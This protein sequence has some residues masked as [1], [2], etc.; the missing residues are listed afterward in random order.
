MADGVLNLNS[1][2]ELEPLV[3]TGGQATPIPLLPDSWANKDRE[4]VMIQP[5]G[6]DIR[7][8]STQI[9]ATKGHRIFDG[10]QIFLEWN[11]GVDW[12]V[13]RVDVSKTVN[14][15]RTVINGN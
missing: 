2:T 10:Q 15:Q 8:G 1:P 14:V 6:G 4:G 5:E 13:V 11:F 12:K 7:I 9:N 3:L